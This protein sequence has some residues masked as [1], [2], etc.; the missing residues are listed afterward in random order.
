MKYFFD[1]EFIEDGQTIDLLSIGIVAADG[2]ELYLESKVADLSKANDFVKKHVIPYLRGGNHAYSRSVIRD[3]VRVFVGDD[4]EPEFWA[5]YASYDW[6]ALCQLFGKMI[7]LP[8]GFPM[9]CRDLKQVLDEDGW[10]IERVISQNTWRVS[11]CFGGD[12]AEFR[13]YG[14]EE[15]NALWDARWLREAHD[16]IERAM[17]AR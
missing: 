5:Y 6:V 8:E 2:R 3:Q 14:F 16:A 7:D 11:P 12:G 13:L 10:S 9:F 1:T 4:P 15:H 17:D